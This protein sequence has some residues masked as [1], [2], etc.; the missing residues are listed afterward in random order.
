MGRKWDMLH[1]IDAP[2]MKPCTKSIVI[3]TAL[4]YVLQMSI[5]AALDCCACFTC[6]CQQRN[7]GDV[8]DTYRD[9]M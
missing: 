1:L 5:H 7:T 4:E 3:H 9:G 8:S 2:E 6:P